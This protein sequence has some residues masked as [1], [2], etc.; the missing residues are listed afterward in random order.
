MLRAWSELSIVR[1]TCARPRDGL[2]AVPAKMTSCMLEPRNCLAACSPI[3]QASASTIFDF[4]EP[5][6]P[7]TAVIPGWKRSVVGRANDLKPRRVSSLRY[8]R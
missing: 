3:T 2:I 1:L 7:T 8:T 4:P 6:G 5:F